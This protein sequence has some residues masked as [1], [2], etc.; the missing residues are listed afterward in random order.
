VTFV[1]MPTIP[2]PANTNRLLPQE[3]QD[4][5]LW[6][7]LKAGQ[8]WPGSLPVTPAHQ[9]Q[10]AVLNG[11]GIGG[12]AGQTAASLRK[13]GFDVVSVGDAPVATA[14]TTVSYPGTAAAGGAYTVAQ[15]LT[16]A[17]ATENT[18]TSGPITLTIG[19]DFTGVTPPPAPAKPGATP[20][21]AASQPATAGQQA[22]VETR[23]AAQ[24]IC[25]GVPDANPAP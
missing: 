10:V 20:S 5:V 2:D 1:T 8:L 21:P 19:S 9:V 13:L 24:N 12:L 14:T 4:D 6:Q 25:S 18:G 16:A 3:P 11:T 22:A 7:M 23:N 15:D 17:P